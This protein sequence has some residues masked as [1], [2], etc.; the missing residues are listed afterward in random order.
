MESMASSDTSVLNTASE[1]FLGRWGLLVSQTNWEKGKIIAEWREALI[2]AGAAPHEYADEAWSRLVG[3]VTPQHVGRLRR[4]YVRFQ[5]QQATFKGLYWSH[6]LAAL[7][8][9]DAELWLEGA[10][11]ND[12]SINEMRSKRW[13]TLGSPAGE[14][15]RPEQVVSADLDE[16]AGPAT[17]G[18][19]VA[20]IRNPRE[21]DADA[22]SGPLHEGPDFG[23]EDSG[24]RHGEEVAAGVDVEAPF[25]SLSPVRPFEGLAELPGDLREAFESF[26]LAILHHKM[27]EWSEVSADDVVAALGAL[28]QLAAAPI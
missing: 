9:N 8:W 10:V 28:Q 23:D 16:D 25:E 11:Q 18:S 20:E 2:A 15:P 7:D 22:E 6:F 17:E 27:K 26:K 12:W 14:E 5:G 21:F 19:T 4:T 24:A 13:E 3:Q 1:P